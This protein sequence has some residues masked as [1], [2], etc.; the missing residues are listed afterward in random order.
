M[1]IIE[2]EKFTIENVDDI[3]Q[4][5]KKDFDTL[6]ENY[7]SDNELWDKEIFIDNDVVATFKQ[8][9]KKQKDLIEQ[10]IDSNDFNEFMEYVAYQ[11]GYEWNVENDGETVFIKYDVELQSQ[12]ELA[13]L[14]SKLIKSGV[15][16][17]FKKL[18]AQV[19]KEVIK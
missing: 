9:W 1:H 15:K 2:I 18:H 13:M 7:I 11:K 14:A 8:A 5:F 16:I 10:D 4:N 12:E 19:L 3:K 17:D 6:L